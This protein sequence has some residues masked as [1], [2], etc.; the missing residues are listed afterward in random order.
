MGVELGKS[1]VKHLVMEK[2]KLI[3]K[4]VFAV[5]TYLSFNQLLHP[6]NEHLMEL[7]I[8]IDAVKRA[9]ARTVNVVF[10]IMAMLDKIVK[11]KLVNQSLQN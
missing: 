9:S 2:F 10:L 8:M 4:K 6:V 3:L 7:L 5:V 1:S 11:Q